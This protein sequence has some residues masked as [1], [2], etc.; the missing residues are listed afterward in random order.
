MKPSRLAKTSGTLTRSSVE[1]ALLVL[2]LGGLLGLE[3][4]VL[5]ERDVLDLKVALRDDGLEDEGLRVDLGLEGQQ[6]ERSES[7]D[8]AEKGE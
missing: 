4:G 3:L 8:C 5:D 1:T 2:G 6:V 7:L